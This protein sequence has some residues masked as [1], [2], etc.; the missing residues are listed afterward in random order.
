MICITNA[1]FV[2]FKLFIL[3]QWSFIDLVTSSSFIAFNQSSFLTQYPDSS[4][5]LNHSFTLHSL[6]STSNSHPIAKQ[7]TT[8][9]HFSNKHTQQKKKQKQN[10]TRY[11]NRS[12]RCNPR[13]DDCKNPGWLS[14]KLKNSLRLLSNRLRNE[15]IPVLHS[16]D[17]LTSRSFTLR[18]RRLVFI[19]AVICE[20]V[21]SCGSS[22]SELSSEKSR[23]CLNSFLS[24]THSTRFH[25]WQSFDVTKSTKSMETLQTFRS[26]RCRVSET[27]K[28]FSKM[29]P[30]KSSK[31]WTNASIVL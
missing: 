18:S 3:I 9:K 15:S 30:T 5:W 2:C 17:S 19:S 11:A 7:P 31:F 26:A 21:R 10:Y 6:L 1:H 24:I 16:S 13:N 25:F 14:N 4:L 20:I 28:H 29:P 23:R 27:K 8:N 12:F 22:A